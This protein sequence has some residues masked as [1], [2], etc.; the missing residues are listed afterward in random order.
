MLR[1]RVIGTASH[2]LFGHPPGLTVL[3]ATESWERFSYFGNAA[4]VVLY[5]VKYLF[6]PGRIETV[7][8][9]GAVRAALEFLFGPLEPQPLASQLFGFYTGLAYFMPIVGGLIA[10]RLLGQRRTVIIGSVL[11]AMGHFMMA[12]EAL[13]LVA[14]AFL[15]LGIGAF[16]PNIST[17]VGSLYAPGDHR[18]DRAYSIFYLGI[19]IGAFLA[20]LICGTLAVQYGWHYGFGAAGVGMLVSLAIY[21]GGARALP[22][23]ALPPAR[24]TLREKPPLERG[25]RQA[26]LALIAVCAPVAL[27]WAA[28]DQ[29]GNTVLLWAE[30]FTDRTVDLGFWRGEI[31]SPWFLS[32]SPLMVFI[33]TPVLV[34][35][36]A[37]QGQSGSEPF[38]ITKMAFGC[39]CVALANLVLATAASTVV[40]KASALWLLGYFTLAT[41]GELH[42]APIGLALISKLAPARALSVLMGVWFATTLPADVLAGFLGGFWSRMGKAEFFVMIALIAALASAVIWVMA[43]AM[44]PVFMRE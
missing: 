1:H 11:M 17:Q 34:R 42:L 10:D 27:F 43:R 3:F 24:T 2:D 38:P 14:L 18:R 23:D 39:L 41:I 22:P 15:I 7:L 30:D 33:F 5:M 37:R 13:F 12:F 44:R 20:P 25:E 6:D 32:L 26:V 8:G 29:Q 35:L 16:K 4:L 21:L 28:Y 31:P 19:N 9:F 40:G 36:W